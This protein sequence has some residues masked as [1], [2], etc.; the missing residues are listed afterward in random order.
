MDD[1]ILI[2]IGKQVLKT[3]SEKGLVREIFMRDEEIR[4]EYE[5]L[6]SS[7]LNATKAREKL[8]EKPYFTLS[9]EKYFISERNM[10]EIVY[11]KRN[12]KCPQVQ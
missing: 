5:E 10:K 9:G 3:L 11:K 2:E 8:C 4:K 1:T 7:G 6:R 12:H